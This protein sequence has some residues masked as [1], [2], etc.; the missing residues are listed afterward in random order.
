MADDLYALLGVTR[1]ATP[2]DIKRAYRRKA[3]EHHPDANHGDPE[4]EARFKELSVAYEVLSDPD[5]RQQYDLYGEAGL[6]GAAGGDPFGGAG[7]GDIFDA[8]FGG[9][10]GSPFGGGGRRGPT[11]PPRGADLEQA[12]EIDFREAVFGAQKDVTVRTAIP[13]GVCE[14]T[15]AAPGTSAQGC[16]ECAGTGQVRRVRQ[17]ILGQMVTAAPCT[18]CNGTGQIIPEPCGGCDG[19][20]RKVDDRTYTVDVPAGVDSGSTLRL[21]GRGAVGPRGGPAGDLY[22]HLRVK[23]D[24][25]FSRDGDDLS[26]IVSLSPAQ[27][28]LGTAVAFETLDGVEDLKVP[29]G[30]QSGDVV[31]LRGQGVPHVRGRGRGDLRIRYVV[32]TPTELT[33]EEDELYRRLAELRGD[34]V[35]APRGGVV[36]RIREAFK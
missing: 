17:S 36:G 32:R 28:A 23:P 34:A 5:K 19:E 22:I 11:G 30:T 15:G 3:R 4:A 8:F 14:A 29:A 18:R 16:P 20:G 13:C 12:V 2:E 10:G 33:D 7:F 9:G 24:E 27:A 31:R 6:G 35:N 21:S 26:A 25:R 1:D